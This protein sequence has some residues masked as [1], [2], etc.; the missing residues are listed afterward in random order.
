MDDYK[1]M[2]T[3]VRFDL[4]C[5]KGSVMDAMS[6]KGP[7]TSII[8]SDCSYAACVKSDYLKNCWLPTAEAVEGS[9]LM[10]IGV[11]NK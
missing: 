11:S 10:L 4:E 6:G 3:M 9:E 7:L 2:L 8:A 1:F 5:M